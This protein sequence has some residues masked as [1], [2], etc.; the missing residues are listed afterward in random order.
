MP[1]FDVFEAWLR[2]QRP[3]LYPSMGEIKNGCARVGAIGAAPAWKDALHLKFLMWD[4]TSGKFQNCLTMTK[5]PIRKQALERVYDRFC[6]LLRTATAKEPHPTVVASRYAAS[7]YAEPFL[8]PLCLRF[9]ADGVGNPVAHACA[10][11][12]IGRFLP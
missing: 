7:P 6:S 10:V 11:A 8:A 5:T 4:G 1:E 9:C 12:P 3:F 2:N